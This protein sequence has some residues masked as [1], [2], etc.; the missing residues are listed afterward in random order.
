MPAHHLTSLRN[1]PQEF[2]DF[3]KA[4][5][6]AYNH[7]PPFELPYKVEQDKIDGKT[8]KYSFN[9]DDKWT[10]ALKCVSLSLSLSHSSLCDSES[11]AAADATGWALI[12]L[13]L[14]QADAVQPQGGSGVAHHQQR[15]H[16]RVAVRPLTALA[17]CTASHGRGPVPLELRSATSN[18]PMIKPICPHRLSGVAPQR[19]R[20]GSLAP[21]SCSMYQHLVDKHIDKL[22]T[23]QRVTSPLLRRT[24]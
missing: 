19:H 7:S 11:V 13:L 9:R 22:A 24:S 21:S 23:T 4:R 12:A 8:I 2:A 3:A 16:W 6:I 20:V 1:R 15:P 14:M 18:L 17:P 5:D 10:A